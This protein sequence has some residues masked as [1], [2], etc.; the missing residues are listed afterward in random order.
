TAGATVLRGV[1]GISVT[2]GEPPTISFTIEGQRREMRPRLIVGA[3]GRGSDV[4]RQIGMK[5]ETAPLHHLLAGLLVD[6]L[7]AWPIN[8]FSIGTE[9]DVM[10]FVFPQG[11]GRVRLY[12]GYGLDQ[13]GRFSGTDSARRFLDA[14]RLSSLPDKEMFASAVPAGPC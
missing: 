5:A 9:G 8:E 6:G 10:F 1:E 14:F 3:D 11:N 12:L 2:A 7:E 4:A 13:R